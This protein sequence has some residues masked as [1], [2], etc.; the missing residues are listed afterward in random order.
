MKSYRQVQA[1]NII[2]DWLDKC[3]KL[4][5]LD[6]NANQK[7]EEGISGASKGYFPIGFEDL[8]VANP[9]LHDILCIQ[10]DIS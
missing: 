1:S 9:Y 8:K 10:T 2:K 5:G 3:D 7:V 4:Q 6:F